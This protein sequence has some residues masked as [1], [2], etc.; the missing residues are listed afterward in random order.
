[1]TWHRPWKPVMVVNS[2]QIQ[3]W[4]IHQLSPWFNTVKLWL[5]HSG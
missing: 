3:A 1:M 4:F 5:R 2:S